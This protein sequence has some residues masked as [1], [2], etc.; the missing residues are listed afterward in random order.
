MDTVGTLGPIEPQINGI[1]A[2]AILRAF[3]TI[4]KRLHDEGPKGLTAYMPLLSKYDLHILEIC[5]SAQE[6]SEELAGTRI[7]AP[8]ELFGGVGAPG[9]CAF[10][11]GPAIGCGR[12]FVL[13]AVAMTFADTTVKL[14][15]MD[16]SDA[17]YIAFGQE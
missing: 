8:R 6:L 9:R 11:S 1:P 16:G 4:Q 14:R 10:P 17:R 12:A 15:I 2:R 3:E 5:K 13:C 7:P